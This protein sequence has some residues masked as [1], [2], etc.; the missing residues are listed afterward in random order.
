MTLLSILINL[1]N[2]CW[3]KIWIFSPNLWTVVQLLASCKHYTENR[4]KIVTLLKTM[5]SLYSRCF[6]LVTADK[7]FK[8]CQSDRNT[9][10]SGTLCALLSL[11]LSPAQSI[12]TCPGR[13]LRECPGKGFVPFQTVFVCFKT[14]LSSP[15]CT[16][17]PD[18]R[19]LNRVLITSAQPDED[20][21][22][23]VLR[24]PNIRHIKSERTPLWLPALPETT[25]IA[26]KAIL[27]VF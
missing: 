25:I 7:P 3:I 22:G 9:P 2:P 19:T 16:L 1:M 13:C 23:W 10:Y 5:S 14:P 15:V 12:Q 4:W 24:E 26:R 21:I 17:S 6:W 20:V 18:A 8:G 27:L 11:F